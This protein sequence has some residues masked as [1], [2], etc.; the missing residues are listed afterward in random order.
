MRQLSLI[1]GHFRLHAFHFS[2]LYIILHWMLWEGLSS[3]KKGS[4]P[5]R[6]KA[7]FTVYSFF[8][9]AE[10]RGNVL[11]LLPGIKPAPHAVEAWRLNH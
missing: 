11:V 3:V 5:L 4:S 10:A 2:V 6:E 8:F 7:G 1:Q 9:L